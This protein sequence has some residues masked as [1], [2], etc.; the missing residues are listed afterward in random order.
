MCTDLRVHIEELEQLKCEHDSD[1]PEDTMKIIYEWAKRQ[2]GMQSIE[3]EMERL[4]KDLQ[5]EKEKHRRLALAEAE[6]K[7]LYG[8][9]QSHVF[10]TQRL[11]EICDRLEDELRQR[12]SAAKHEEPKGRKRSISD[13]RDVN[14]PMSKIKHSSSVPEIQACHLL[15]ESVTNILE[16]ST[17]SNAGQ[18]KAEAR[19]GWVSKL[20]NMFGRHR[21]RSHDNNKSNGLPEVESLFDLPA[22]NERAQLFC[23]LEEDGLLVWIQEVGLSRYSQ[24]II[25]HAPCGTDLVK[26]VSSHNEH[27]AGISHPLHQKK[28]QLAVREVL[29]EQASPTTQ[30]DHHWVAGWLV[31]IGLPQYCDVFLEG[32]VD[33]TVLNEITYD[34]LS[35]LQVTNPFH[36]ISLKRAI[37][38]LRLASYRKDYLKTWSS[39]KGANQ[40]LLWPASRVHDWLKYIDLGDYIGHLEGAGLHGALMVL[41]VKFTEE[42]LARLL[43]IPPG[44]VFLRKHL[45]RKFLD[46]VG[47]VVAQSKLD[48]QQVKNFIALDPL[49]KPKKKPRHKK[50]LSSSNDVLL[51]PFEFGKSRAGGRPWTR[52]SPDVCVAS[53]EN[54]PPRSNSVSA[55][56][57]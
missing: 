52:S 27:L 56:I 41:E 8:K 45:L 46:I 1:V 22:E 43:G 53:V 50:D 21:V 31:D 10:E 16:L 7:R 14:R 54:T 44:K 28:L 13:L 29:S 42:S 24:G 36:Q 15:S 38:G 40:V 47:P 48:A 12:E 3:D 37:Q 35:L 2:L 4:K 19:K 5:I 30:L 33:G 34:D 6:V 20:G 55:L 51:C 9:L 32:L 17:A 18:A 57:D 39:V 26:L 23:T 25:R 11:Q 49:G